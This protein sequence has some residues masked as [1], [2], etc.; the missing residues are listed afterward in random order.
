MKE[1]LKY[2]F[3]NEDGVSNVEVV[4][5]ISVCLIVVT[6]FIMFH[7]EILEFLAGGVRKIDNKHSG[8]SY[9]DGQL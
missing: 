8:A 6:L 3:D 4:V 9:I 7:D 5:W 2:V 1:R